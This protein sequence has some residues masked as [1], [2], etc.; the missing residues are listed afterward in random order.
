MGSM[1][2]EIITGTSRPASLMA[3]RAPRTVALRFSVSC[4]VSMSSRSMPPSSSPRVCSRKASWTSS[5]V[6]PP[7]TV[8]VLVWGPSDPAAKRGLSPV[9]CVA[10]ACRAR[11]AAAALMACT[12]LSRPYSESTMRVP[13]KVLVQ[14]MSAP[15]RR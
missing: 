6:T 5:N 8:M 9:W 11:R 10:T 3:C 2:T 14:M 12:R 1:V 4:A 13:P 7:V 15:A